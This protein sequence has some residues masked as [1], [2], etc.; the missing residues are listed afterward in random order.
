MQLFSLR[1]SHEPSVDSLISNPQWIFFPSKLFL[2]SLCKLFA[3]KTCFGR[4]LHRSVMCCVRSHIPPALNWSVFFRN[5]VSL[6]CQVGG[7]FWEILLG[8]QSDHFLADSTFTDEGKMWYSSTLKSISVQGAYTSGTCAACM[9]S[10][11]VRH[12]GWSGERNELKGMGSGN[13][14]S[15]HQVL[16][17]FPCVFQLFLHFYSQDSLKMK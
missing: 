3:F 16:N 6:F 7:V 4:E 8:K 2:L 12:N 17:C 13:T 14:K 1:W 5:K 9:K 10:E 15:L 11:S